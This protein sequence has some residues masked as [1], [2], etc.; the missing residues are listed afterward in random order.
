MKNISASLS[1]LF[2]I[3]NLLL[4]IC[5]SILVYSAVNGTNVPNWIIDFVQNYFA[6]Y[7]INKARRP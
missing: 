5:V 1:K 7:A 3:N 6:Y 2:N 4:I